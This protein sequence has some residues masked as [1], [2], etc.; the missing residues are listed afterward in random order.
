[1]A[2][3]MKHTGGPYGDACSSYIVM[4]DREYTV[5]EFVEDV[6]KEKPE[7]WGDFKIATDL[8]YS[9]TTSI[10]MCVYKYGQIISSFRKPSTAK[11]KIKE[12]VAHGGYTNM[13][14]CIKPILEE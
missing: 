1:M 12:V 7:E 13:D 11:M 3:K 14:Y 5:Q 9:H 4:L 6:I 8:K 2:F 10:D